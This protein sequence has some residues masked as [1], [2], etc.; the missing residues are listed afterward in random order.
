[1]K[2]PYLDKGGHLIIFNAYLLKFVDDLNSR[3]SSFLCGRKKNRDNFPEIYSS[4]GSIS[5]L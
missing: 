3:L 4:N 2:Q 5:P 1:M